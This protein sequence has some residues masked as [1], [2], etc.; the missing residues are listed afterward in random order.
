MHLDQ[1]YTLF[2]KS[3]SVSTDTRKITQGDIFFALKGDNFNGN[4]F[5]SEALEKGAAFAVIDEEAHA[6]SERHILVED[7][8]ETLQALAARHRKQLGIPVVAITGS[9]GK[10]TT[11][12]LVHRVLQ[13]KYRTFSTP[14]NFNNH[15]GV[16]L[17]LLQLTE[18]TEMAVI[19]M[20]DNHLGEVAALCE[21]ALP[22]FGIITNIG[23][24]HLE[25]FGSFENNIRAKS[26][27]FHYLIQHGG[28]AFI[29][30][31]DPILSNMAKRFPNPVMYGAKGDFAY[32]EYVGADPYVRYRDS[33]SMAVQT[34]ISG[35]FNFDNIMAAIC[36]GKFFKVPEENIHRAIA[37]Y[38]PGN[39]RSQ[40]LEKGSN[41]ILMDAYNANPSSVAVAVESFDELKTYKQKTVILGDMYELGETSHKEHLETVRMVLGRSFDMAIFCGA[42]FQACQQEG[43]LFFAEKTDLVTYLQTADIQNTYI[44]LKGSRAMKM[45]DLVEYL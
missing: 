17:S 3:G 29:N 36:V 43:G 23:K 30:S 33:M 10:T 34:R 6:T 22:D 19:E 41:T 37:G 16:P 28:N 8:L 21:I 24:D 25:G 31:K 44:L 5:A 45:E 14:G 27:L 15:I 4:R 39:N 9:N 32:A 12:E 18:E 20:G 38:V 7:S 2:L 26:E 35:R 11:K 1:L 42:A 40:L 13:E